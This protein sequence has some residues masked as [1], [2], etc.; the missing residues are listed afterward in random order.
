MS[1]HEVFVQYNG[2]GITRYYKVEVEAPDD[3]TVD[4]EDLAVEEAEKLLIE[5]FDEEEPDKDDYDTKE[6]YD[7]AF[8]EYKEELDSWLNDWSYEGANIVDP[9]DANELRESLVGLVSGE[10]SGNGDEYEE[11]FSFDDE[12]CTVNTR[13][14]I[15]FDNEG[16]ITDVKDIYAEGL[17]WEGARSSSWAEC[18]PDYDWLKEELISE[19]GLE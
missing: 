9:E 11:D 19:L 3:E 10:Y 17:E 18:Y 4:L 8:A 6:E 12:Y 14:T 16:A 15:V 1:K 2:D 5:E 7:E 13:V